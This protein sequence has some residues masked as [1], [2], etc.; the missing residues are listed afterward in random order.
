M[1]NTPALF[2]VSL[3]AAPTLFAEA[4][5]EPASVFG[6]APSAQPSQTAPSPASLMPE[7]LP[8]LDKSPLGKKEKTR[9]DKT[10]VAEDALKQKIK[11]R[12]VK[13]KALR[14]PA[15]QAEWEKAR[16]AKTDYEKRQIM[17]NYYKLLY[18]RMEQIDGSLKTEIETL[19][20][21]YI[22]DVTQRRI[23]PTVPPET[24]RASR[25]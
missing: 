23:A 22:S 5:A 19:R 15:V 24:A 1:K 3:L 20:D 13:T 21:T 6:L 11:M 10:A 14:D 18:G 7:E 2:F 9:P 17:T 12:E 25:N 4:P 16:V 8:P